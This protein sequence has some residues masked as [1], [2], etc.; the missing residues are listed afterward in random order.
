MVDTSTI[1]TSALLIVTLVVLAFVVYELYQYYET[2]GSTGGGSGGGGATQ[3]SV[4]II[5]PYTRG[6]ASKPQTF[7]SSKFPRSSDQPSGIAFT[8]AMWM[9]VRDWMPPSHSGM[10]PGE[11]VVFTKG[12]PG[13]QGPSCPALTVRTDDPALSNTLNVYVDTF[14]RESPTEK[15]TIYDL[16][17]GGEVAPFFHLAIVVS[18]HVVK[19]YVNGLIKKRE[20]LNGIPQQNQ[21]SL[22]VA[23]DGARESFTGE[24]GSFTYYNYAMTPGA[25]SSLA[26]TPP[27]EAPTKSTGDLPPYQASRWWF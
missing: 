2:G 27:V 26:N 8:Y 16:P 1:T 18:D 14:N 21:S 6:N 4:P 23:P 15:V 13:G 12:V 25:I 9:R 7:P 11:G 22:V 10:P 3:V 24:I 5:G 20:T 19:V 17:A